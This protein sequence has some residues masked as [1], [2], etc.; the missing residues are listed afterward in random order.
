MLTQTIKL[1]KL[2]GKTGTIVREHYLRDDIP[3]YSPLCKNCPSNNIGSKNIQ[4][5]ENATHYAIPCYDIVQNYLELLEFQELKGL[6]ILQTIASKTVQSSGVRTFNRLLNICKDIRRGSII[7]LN[8]N[9]QKSYVP[10]KISESL[11]EWFNKCCAQAANFYA[12]HLKGTIPIIL[13]SENVEAYKPLVQ[14]E[15][16]KVYSMRE[17]LENMWKDV[18]SILP[19]FESLHLALST[20]TVKDLS[21][22]YDNHLSADVL[23]AGIKAGRY[24]RGY[25]RVN[26]HNASEEAFVTTSK[27]ALKDVGDI[28]I[29][30]MVDRNRAIHGDEVVV[31][32]LPE[33]QWKSRCLKLVLSIA[34]D[35]NDDE[36]QA[37]SLILPTGKVVGV[38]ERCWR[39]YVA[40]LPEED[41]T[42]PTFKSKERILAV[43]YDY[44]I[45]K[46]R[47]AT[48][49]A[50]DIRNKRIV[51]R[52]D[53][54]EKES[55]YPN[56]HFVQS[57]GEIGDLETEIQS[58]LI[59]HDVFF[60]EFAQNLLNE[61][62]TCTAENPWTLDSDQISKRR[63][64]RDS[65]LIFSIDP[66]GCEDVDDALSV[67]ELPGGKLELGVHIADV[68]HFV[69]ELSVVDLE[70]RSRSTSVY[71]PDR[72]YDMLPH[73][74]SGNLCSLL[75]NVDRY[76]VSVLWKLDSKCKV[77][78]VWYGRTIIKSKYKLCYEAAQDILYGSTVENMLADIPELQGLD[79]C[80]LNMRFQELKD[81]LSK[82][83]HI[84][85][86][87]R[88]ER[89]GAGGLELNS[90]NMKFEI[91][92]NLPSAVTDV[93]SAKELA[94]HKTVA[95]CMIFANHW[96]AKKI[97]DVYPS[98]AVLRRHP[99]PREADLVEL[100]KLAKSKGFS[101][102][103]HSNKELA[104]SLEKAVDFHD[105]S[106][107]QIFRILATQTMNQATYCC[108][109]CY[110]LPELYH[111]G[112]GLDRYTHFTSPIRRYADILVHRLLL[113]AVKETDSNLSMDSTEIEKLCN[114]MNIRHRAA[115]DLE[116]DAQQLFLTFYFEELSGQENSSPC[117]VDAIIYALRAN[118]LL[119]FI[120][121]YGIKGAVCLCN[122]DRKVAV[123][124]DAVEWV[125][126]HLTNAESCLTVC[127]GGILQQYRIFDHITV[128]VKVQKSRS[129][130]NRIVL[131]LVDNKPYSKDWN[132]ILKEKFDLSSLR[133]NKDEELETKATEN[134]KPVPEKTEEFNMYLFLQKIRALTLSE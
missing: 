100:Q 39:N 95:E 107:N 32:L 83:Y 89:L 93:K 31:E 21:K 4:L 102:N 84:A 3:C 37:S 58:L 17:Y 14:H 76:A 61:L 34:S 26:K 65:H 24:F 43:P 6:I 121:K 56:G 54:W 53:G 98:Q 118:G 131:E 30:G 128:C 22:S 40:T 57:L 80:E 1:V 115:Q 108:T 116:K 47:I 28:F 130:L 109:G 69:Q 110:S 23:E 50:D 114:H 8:E 49:R 70:A 77:Q 92:R 123:V 19:L 16:V 73:V 9:C 46:I 119:V 101:L 66:K 29:S 60:R 2:K 103:I 111:Y 52:I 87:I 13:I 12:E 45:P 25:L 97:N 71:L 64:L 15:S 11:E 106:I 127:A 82:L 18:E 99:N 67:R 112:L 132:E 5:A 134:V 35:D 20:G 122:K 59:E 88:R 124:Q 42:N 74:L 90:I 96:V 38:L 78:D 117:L 105:P 51:V 126:G 63:D 129:H 81:S 33:N 44:R 125:D 113:A 94:I 68:T 85:N 62:P 27:T 120:P 36:N 41:V 75:G 91:D 10:R 7:F 48:K 133:E 79:D 86:V 104:A 55:Q 72:R